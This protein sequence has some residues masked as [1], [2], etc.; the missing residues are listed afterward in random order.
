MN[1]KLIDQIKDGTLDPK[2]AVKKLNS[3]EATHISEINI[4]DLKVKVQPSGFPSLDEFMFIKEGES[5]L[6]VVGARP[7]VGKSSFMF[8]LAAN[9]ARDMNV[10][11]YSLEMSKKSIVT[12]LMGLTMSRAISDLQKGTA[13]EGEKQRAHAALSRLGLYIDDR[14]RLDISTIRNSANVF[15]RQKPVG[16]VVVDYLQLIKGVEKGTR[17]AEIGVIT[18]ELKALAKDIGCPVVVGAQLN[19]ASENRGRDSGDYTP[20]LADLRESGNIEQDADQ[21]VF[22]SRPEM[23]TGTRAGEADIV[24]AKNRNGKS[25]KVLM[26][27]SAE[28]TKFYDMRADI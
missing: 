28:M 11:I 12:R 15:H 18:G 4:T 8:Q 1:L 24:I 5:E 14:P 23:Y 13:D 9:V 27:F 19:R 22:L 2:E 6:I 10:L 21:V 16:L 17:D 3:H 7:S 20:Q 26:K 25:G